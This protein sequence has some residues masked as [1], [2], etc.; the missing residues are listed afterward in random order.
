M[1]FLS[2]LISWDVWTSGRRFIKGTRAWFAS[3]ILLAPGLAGIGLQGSLPNFLTYGLATY[4][5]YLGSTLQLVGI[6]A[7]TGRPPRLAFWLG[8][9][10]AAFAAH[11]F[12]FF[13]RPDMETRLIIYNSYNI[14][15]N[16][17]AV[18]LLI[19]SA[20]PDMKRTRYL[21]AWIFF[22]FALLYVF[23]LVSE[24]LHK[25]DA[26]LLSGSGFEAVFFLGCIVLIASV[27]FIELK[28]VNS[29]LLSRVEA[30]AREKALLMR[31]MNHRTK[32]NLALADSLVSLEGHRFDDPRVLDSMESIRARLRSIGL[33][34]D[35]LYRI[36]AAGRTLRLD[37]YLL[38]VLDALAQGALPAKVEWELAEVEADLDVAIPIGLIA[39]EL[40]T[41]SLKHAYPKGGEGRVFV[42]LTRKDRDCLLAVRDWGPGFSGKPEGGLGSLIVAS[43]TEQLGA[44]LNWKNEGGAVV[45]LVFSPLGPAQSSPA[46]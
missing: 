3:F 7:F 39:G 20:E 30:G 44:S 19:V 38:G 8:A 24:L 36:E 10:T 32:N 17:I 9:A 33:L 14:A 31:E 35:S 12:F 37:L 23:R 22:C 46:Q 42:G 34:H 28:L 45:E 5:L 2:V 41:N 40:V 26:S 16:G 18:A 15:I 4:L 13:A 29:R 27:V 11:A 1:A 43:L 21:A 25:P 6:L